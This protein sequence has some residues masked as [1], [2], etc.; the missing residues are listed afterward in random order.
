MVKAPYRHE[1]GIP[2]H[3]FRGRRV[4]HPVSLESLDRVGCFEVDQVRRGWSAPVQ[5]ACDLVKGVSGVG[6]SHNQDR[7]IDDY[8]WLSLS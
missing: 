7:G 4:E 6:Q 8:Q 1:G 5:E 3:R 2:D